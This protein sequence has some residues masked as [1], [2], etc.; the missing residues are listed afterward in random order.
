[1]NKIVIDQKYCKGCGLCIA[2][3]PK[4][5][6]AIS[7]TANAKGYKC[8]EQTD[9]SK[10]IACKLCAIMCPDSAITVYKEEKGGET[11]EC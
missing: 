1:M 4:G 2:V 8:A 11:N 9:E 7:D 10:C 6:I 5:I 3:C